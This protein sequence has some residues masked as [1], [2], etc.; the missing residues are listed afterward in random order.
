MNDCLTIRMGF[1]NCQ[2][3]WRRFWQV[4]LIC[5]RFLDI[6][7][8]LGPVITWLGCFWLPC[9]SEHVKSER[10]IFFWASM[11]SSYI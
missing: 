2:E 6:D 8:Y 9:R 4:C 3:E 5:L 1:M 10:Q 11:I 7:S